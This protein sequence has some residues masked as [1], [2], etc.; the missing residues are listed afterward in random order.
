MMAPV[1]LAVAAPIFGLDDRCPR[2]A[3]AQSRRQA[4]GPVAIR[5]AGYDR[6]IAATLPS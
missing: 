1:P 4:D 3:A 5:K 6:T 2:A